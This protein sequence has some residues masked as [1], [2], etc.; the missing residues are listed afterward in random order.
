MKTL[1]LASA[2]AMA[3]AAGASIAQSSPFAAMKGKIKPGMYDYKMEMDMGQVPGMPAG[4]GKQ[5]FAQQTCVT[6]ADLEKG[7]AFDKGRD[8]KSPADCEVK[9]FKLSG[10]TATYKMVCK[11]QH[12]M[13][14]D[15]VITFVPNGYKG[16][17]KMA[18]NR[19]GQK[20]NMT[21]NYEGKYIGACP[22]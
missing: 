17:T 21:S 20:M 18:M 1:I 22:K 8:G 6:E 11:G 2:A 3:F 10:N 5:S 15:S 13:E 12:A 14:A 16:T 7:T 9:D 4:M 19:E